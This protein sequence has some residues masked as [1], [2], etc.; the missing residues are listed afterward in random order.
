M[1]FFM[2]KKIFFESF[3][4]KIKK[5]NDIASNTLTH[6]DIFGLLNP[7]EKKNIMICLIYMR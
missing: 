5:N 7:N 2:I 6:Q 4:N 1:R 3:F